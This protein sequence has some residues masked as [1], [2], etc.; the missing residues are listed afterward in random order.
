MKQLDMTQYTSRWDY[1]ADRVEFTQKPLD[2]EPNKFNIVG[3]FVGDWDE[4]LTRLIQRSGGGVPLNF[5]SKMEGGEAPY[6]ATLDRNDLT[7]S[8]LSENTVFLN[9]II[10]P[11]I[12]RANAP[13]IYKM[14]DWFGFVGKVIVKIHIQH[15]GQVFPYH[16]DDLTT[17]RNNSGDKHLMEDDPARWARIEVQ[18]KD[19]DWGHMWCV[20]NT[21]WKQ[22]K[23]GEIM[24]HPWHNIPHG[25]ANCGSTPRICLQITGE[26]TAE[27][28]EKL[29]SQLG[30]IVL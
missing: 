12:N 11:L 27:L 10:P 5:L 14:V 6:T 9:R 23:A 17:S 28:R 4:E 20:G 25:T 15:P 7:S 2:P 30:D 18:L 1:M 22:W 16:F 19:W 21:Y 8:G 24:F 29:N 26:T 13:T 3:R